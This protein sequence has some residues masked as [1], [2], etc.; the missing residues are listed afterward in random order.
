MSRSFINLNQP[1]VT[2]IKLSAP[3]A[4]GQ[5]LAGNQWLRRLGTNTLLSSTQED[6]SSILTKSKKEKGNLMGLSVRA[7]ERKP[8][9]IKAARFTGKNSKEIATWVNNNGGMAKARGA[10]VDIL[11]FDNDGNEELIDRVKKNDYVLRF[12]FGDDE[13]TSIVFSV[14]DP[15]T[16]EFTYDLKKRAS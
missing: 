9:V 3:T 11:G 4:I 5:L 8:E 1:A 12:E 2:G 15:E 10:F 14:W 13:Y 7:Y 6:I 16:F